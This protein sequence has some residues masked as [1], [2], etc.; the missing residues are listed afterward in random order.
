MNV[1]LSLVISRR[2]VVNVH[3]SL[4]NAEFHFMNAYRSPVIGQSKSRVAIKG[5]N[6]TGRE[7]VY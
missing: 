7:C 5:G 4:V 6:T 2:S 1:G 3:L